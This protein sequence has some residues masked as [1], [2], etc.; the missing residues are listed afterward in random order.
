MEKVDICVHFLLGK[1]LQKVNQVS[2]SKLSSYGVT[3]V[4]YALLRQL[5]RKDGQ[6]GFELAERLQLD[7]ATITGIIDRLEQNGF[8]DRRVD[9]NDR[10]NKLVFLTDKGRSME[11]PLCQK[12]DEMNEEVMSDL[13][14][15]EIQQ[16]KKILY[17]IGIKNK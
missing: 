9:P 14:D 8:I 2:K 11:V 13:S 10:R 6:F 15:V 3:P 7:S 4:Q 17:D 1:A 5:W 12:M 16:F